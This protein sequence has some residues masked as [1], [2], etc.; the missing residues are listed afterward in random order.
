M[1]TLVSIAMMALV[2]GMVVTDPGSKAPRARKKR[3]G[4]LVELVLPLLARLTAEQAQPAVLW[5]LRDR[6]SVSGRLALAARFQAAA[7]ALQANDPETAADAL[8]A[9]IGDFRP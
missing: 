9:A 1:T 6:M 4:I 3:F 2:I 8:A 5:V 7:A